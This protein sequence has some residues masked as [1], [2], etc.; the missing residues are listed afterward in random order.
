M[1]IDYDPQADVMY[2]Q[3]GPG[4]VDYTREMAS[5]FFVDVDEKGTPVG[6]EILSVRRFLAQKEPVSVTLNIDSLAKV[7]A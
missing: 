7:L 3:L 6:I 4:E 2:I 1:Q 5:D